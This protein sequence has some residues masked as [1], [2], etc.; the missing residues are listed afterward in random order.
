MSE[1]ILTYGGNALTYGAGSSVLV[2]NSGDPYNPLGLPPYTMRF[3]FGDASYDPTADSWKSGATWTRVSSSPNVWDYTRQDWNWSSEFSSAFISAVN[4]VYL[5]GANFTDITNAISLF[6]NCS[7]LRNTVLFDTSNCTTTHQMFDRSGIASAPA[8]PLPACVSADGMFRNCSYLTTIDGLDLHLCTTTSSV[9]AY[10]T[11]LTDIGPVDCSSSQTMDNFFSN[12]TSLVTSPVITTTSALHSIQAIFSGCSR[13]T[14]IRPFET[15]R[16]TNASYA[17]RN[18]SSLESSG[19]PLFDFSVVSD[20]RD[21]FKGCTSLQDIPAGLD[22]R[23]VTNASDM[24]NGC[25]SLSSIPSGIQMISVTDAGHMFQDCTSLVG[26][27]A[28]LG[29][30]S[31]TNA[32]WMF[33]NCSSL[34]SLPVITSTTLANVES[35]F[36]NCRNVNGGA[37][38]MYNQLSSQSTPPSSH[39]SCFDGCG[40][41]TA[42][43]VQELEQIP[44]S[45]GGR[46]QE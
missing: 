26:L 5:L 3:Q 7:Q 23:S 46:M 8:Y 45:W 31:L 35:A 6:S 12:C 43:G 32:Q 21:M 18:C 4:P 14:T 42:L 39:A 10:C 16:V 22:F 20:A 34:V 36:A 25:T 37:L 38:A 30:G 9:F 29:L 44:E 17:F 40:A 15:G 2:I 28:S 19:I 1:L 33:R 41:N 24:F 27:P 13:L 11:S